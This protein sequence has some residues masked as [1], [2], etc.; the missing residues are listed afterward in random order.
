MKSL[1][2]AIEFFKQKKVINI[3]VL[4]LF[5][6]LLVGTSVIRLQNLPLLKDQTTGN[7]IPL[8]LDPFYFLRLSFKHPFS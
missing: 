1:N 8:A 7:S 5:L 3:I 2:K 6:V 4:I